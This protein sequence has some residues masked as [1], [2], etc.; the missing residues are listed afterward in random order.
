MVRN[1]PLARQY[2]F[3]GVLDRVAKFQ[4]LPL[5]DSR[6]FLQESGLGSQ[7]FRVS[8]NPKTHSIVRVLHIESIWNRQRFCLAKR[9]AG[10]HEYDGR[11]LGG[12]NASA[13]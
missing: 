12:H 7:N 1:L 13:A 8:V 11:W 9:W 2:E 4:P 3:T 5:H 6:V 10:C